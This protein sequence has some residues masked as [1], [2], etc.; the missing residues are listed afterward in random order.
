[1]KYF[2]ISEIENKESILL[3]GLK[4]NGN[5]IFLF[6]DISQAE[7]IAVNQLGINEFSLFEIDPK[8]ILKNIKQD[9]VAEFG[10]SHQWYLELDLIE[11]RRIKRLS[12]VK[13]NIF[14]MINESEYSKHKAMGYSDEQYIEILKNFPERLAR[15]NLLNG[16]DYKP[17]R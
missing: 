3:N 11:P 8:G 10:S 2:H 4:S 5:A 12:D 13:K 1:M 16:T 7:N 17:N 15:H 6:D 9:N 14:D